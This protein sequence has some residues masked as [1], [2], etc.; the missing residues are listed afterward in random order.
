MQL[1]P[2]KEKDYRQDLQWNFL[3]NTISVYQKSI[4]EEDYGKITGYSFSGGERNR[5][6]LQSGGNFD[7]ASLV[8]GIDFRN[9]GRGFVIFDY[10][11]DGFV[12]LGIIT[13][14]SPRFRIA[15]NNFKSDQRGDIAE[16]GSAFISLV[17]GN[18][19]AKSTEQWSPRNPF[20]ARMIA[21]IGDKKRMFQLSCGE[22][23]ASQNSGSVHVGLG[24]APQIDKLEIIWPSGKRTTEENVKAGERRTFYENPK[25]QPR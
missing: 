16:N 8:S 23:L 6:F 14:Q 5:L 12:D 10:D 22:G 20:G 25:M 4:E 17:G 19:K 1:D 24:D 13:S 21:T 3:D 18:T 9:D 7:E 11:H 15:K 2:T